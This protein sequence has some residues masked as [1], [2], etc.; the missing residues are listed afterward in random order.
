MSK[1]WIIEAH[2]R[3]ASQT[4][5]WFDLSGDNLV[6]DE[7]LAHRLAQSHAQ[8]LNQEAK[9]N[10]QDW[11]ACAHEQAVGIHTI[12]GYVGHDPDPDYPNN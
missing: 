6:T 12:T 2:S 8:V 10:A 5:R 9:L 4:L 7:Q 3:Q 1:I 11:V